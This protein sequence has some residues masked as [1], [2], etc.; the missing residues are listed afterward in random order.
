[1]DGMSTKQPYSW[2]TQV[3]HSVDSTEFYNI[4]KKFAA[5]EL[6]WWQNSAG[7]SAG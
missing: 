4:S 1:M 3:V 6:F 5:A 2:S 7:S